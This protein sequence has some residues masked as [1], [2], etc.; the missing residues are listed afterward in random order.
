M[1][2]DKKTWKKR[3][4]D[5][6]AARPPKWLGQGGSGQLPGERVVASTLA[7]LQERGLI[8]HGHVTC[9]EAGEHSLN[10]PIKLSAAGVEAARKLDV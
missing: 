5:P 4:P 1:N 9:N 2:V 6:P 10:L 3:S 7:T 8:Q